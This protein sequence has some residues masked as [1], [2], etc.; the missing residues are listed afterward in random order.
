MAVFSPTVFSSTVFNT[1]EADNGWLGGTFDDPYE[2]SR[3]RRD[4]QLALKE[5]ED[6]II[7][8]RLEAQELELQKRELDDAKDKQTKRQIAAI[9]RKQ[10]ILKQDI[11]DEL[12]TLVLMQQAFNRRNEEALALLMS[13]FPWLNIETGGT[14]H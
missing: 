2:R 5:K 9:E 13:A 11:A 7:R 14:M 4:T 3:K 6:E 10:A 1:G 8:L 12:A